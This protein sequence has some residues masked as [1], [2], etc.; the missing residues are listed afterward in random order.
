MTR[1]PSV[2]TVTAFFLATL[3]APRMTAAQADRLAGFVRAS[4]PSPADAPIVRNGRFSGYTN[5][6]QTNA[7]TWRQHGNLFLIGQPDVGRAIAQ[8]KADIAEE[9]GLPGL[10]LDEGFLDAWLEASPAE[11]E[12]PGDEDTAR[13]L[14]RGL[15]PPPESEP[16]LPDRSE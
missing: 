16:A 1:H 10:V 12:D 8:N 13:A 6:W 2:R 7:W 9:M 5:Y 4:G 3:I 15:C 11:L 14:D